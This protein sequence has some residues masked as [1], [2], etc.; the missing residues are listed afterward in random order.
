MDRMSPPFWVMEDEAYPRQAL[1]KSLT[2][3]FLNASVPV[4]DENSEIEVDG[5][6]VYLDKEQDDD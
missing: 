3:C 5:W 4:E 2:E 1:V 6:P